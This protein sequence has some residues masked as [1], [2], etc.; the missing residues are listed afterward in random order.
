MASC[1]P[2]GRPVQIAHRRSRQHL[3]MIASTPRPRLAVATLFAVTVAAG[4]GSRRFPDRIPLVL[5]TY[6]GDVLWAAMVYWIIV[7]VRPG[8]SRLAAAI[9]T[10]GFALA[11]EVS[12]LYRAPWLDAIRATRA[13]ALALGQGFLWSDLACYAVGA[14]LALAIDV[15]L[16]RAGGNRTGDS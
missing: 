3:L 2:G 6:A 1:K 4:L 11:I 13:G 10:F 12:Q 9:G 5:A 8:L 15:A 7:F 16:F 14:G